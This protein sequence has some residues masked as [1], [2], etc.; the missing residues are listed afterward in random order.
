MLLLG[1][2]CGLSI[3]GQQS[4]VSVGGNDAPGTESLYSPAFC[5]DFDRDGRLTPA[6]IDAMNAAFQAGLSRA[7]FDG[8]G[9]VDPQDVSAFVNVWVRERASDD[10][11]CRYILLDPLDR[12]AI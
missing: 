1:M 6:D 9:V 12:G 10:R 2:G 5:A 8:N 4:S 11:N 3:P 7:D